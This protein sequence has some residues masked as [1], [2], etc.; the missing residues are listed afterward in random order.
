MT[1]LIAIHKE[2][3]VFDNEFKRQLFIEDLKEMNPEI[4]YATA[5]GE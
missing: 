1:Y 2:I 5:Q 3:F 4:E